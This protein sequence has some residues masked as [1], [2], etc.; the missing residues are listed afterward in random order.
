MQIYGQMCANILLESTSFSRMVALVHLLVFTHMWKKS[1]VEF[2]V[3]RAIIG[4]KHYR[5][6]VESHK[7]SCAEGI[8]SY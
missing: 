6:Y 1:H 4:Q 3:V 8:V 7:I 2:Y 5:K